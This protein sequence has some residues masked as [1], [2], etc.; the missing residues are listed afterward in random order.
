MSNPALKLGLILTCS[1][2]MLCRL[3]LVSTHFWKCAAEHIKPCG[4][5][6]YSYVPNSVENAVRCFESSVRPAFQYPFFRSNVLMY[7]AFRSFS[8]IAWTSGM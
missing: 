2:S 7:F 1:K 3:S 4:T 8:Y 5:T 6:L